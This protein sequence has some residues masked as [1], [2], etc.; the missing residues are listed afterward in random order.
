VWGPNG[1]PARTTVALNL[2]S[3]LAFLGQTTVLVGA[4][5]YG[6][7]IAQAL[8]LLDEAPG[9]AT[10]TGRQTRAAW[11]LAPSARLAPEV[12]PGPRVLTG[13]PKAE[14]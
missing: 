6:G 11:T 10:A 12:W 14:R 7:C 9:L 4:D 2:A 8:F 1:A 5:T 3:E 13:L